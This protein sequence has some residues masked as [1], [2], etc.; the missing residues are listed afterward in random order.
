M[1][2]VTKFFPKSSSLPIDKFVYNALYKKNLGYYAKKNPIGKKGDFI[3]AP[4]ISF[5]FSEMIAVWVISLWEHLGK[6]KDF[7]I[8]ELGPGSGKMCFNMMR[9]FKKFP[10]F[11]A[12]CNI[13]CMKKVPRLKNYNK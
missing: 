6:P 13:F 10:S 11:L 8:V 7:N 3:T 2:P 12:S 5:L 4:E 9:V 1:N